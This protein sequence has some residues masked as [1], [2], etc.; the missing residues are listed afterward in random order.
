M[1]CVLVRWLCIFL[2]LFSLS[3]CGL[4]P[5][6]TKLLEQP[7]QGT[8]G[9]VSWQFKEGVVIRCMKKLVVYLF[10]NKLQNPCDAVE[11][12]SQRIFQSY[13]LIYVDKRKSEYDLSWSIPQKLTFAV[14]KNVM[15]GEMH[16]SIRGKLLIDQLTDQRMSGRLQAYANPENNINGYFNITSCNRENE[17]SS[18]YLR[19]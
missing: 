9:G 19:Q 14:V 15:H 3:S 11:N 12:L 6:N 8:V 10:P 5:E 16:A 13:V 17:D 4:F 18:K 7:L 2:L 1:R